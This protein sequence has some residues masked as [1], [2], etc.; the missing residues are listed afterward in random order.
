MA[1]ASP[2]PS[3][4][5]LNDTGCH[6]A[7][8]PSHVVGDPHGTNQHHEDLGYEVLYFLFLCITMGAAA[9]GAVRGSRL[10]YTVALLFLGLALGSLHIWVDLGVLGNSMNAWIS[11]GPHTMLAV[12]L[13]ALVF[14]SAFSL[15]S[16]KIPC[17]LL[18][19]F[20]T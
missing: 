2:S 17:I 1:V 12:F 11:I 20:R 14:E 5:P 8:G 13:P 19:F 9:R 15:V 3:T 10:P 7:V 16:N 18:S 6:N 4:S